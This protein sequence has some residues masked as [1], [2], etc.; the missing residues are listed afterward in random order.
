M[1]EEKTTTHRPTI[2]AEAGDAGHRASEA[3]EAAKERAA[4]VAG[5]LRELGV[6]FAAAIRAAAATDEAQ[7]FRNEIRDGLGQLRDEVDAAF[8][9]VRTGTKRRAGE[10]KG[11]LEVK[12]RSEFA[13]AV[14]N[15]NS[16]LE[17]LAGSMEPSDDDNATVAEADAANE[18]T[19]VIEDAEVQA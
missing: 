6:Q 2:E 5:E 11:S 16:A 1:N 13:S 19:V 15:L 14:R 3:A 18:P 17:R 10:R 9:N 7:E 12:L 8:T 4:S